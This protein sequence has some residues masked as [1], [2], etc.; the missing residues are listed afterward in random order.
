MAHKGRFYEIFDVFSDTILSGNPVAIVHETEGLTNQQ[1]QAIAREFNLSETVFMIPPRDPKHIARLRIFKPDGEMAFAGHPTI[2]AAVALA[3]KNNFRNDALIILEEEVGIIRAVVD[4][5]EKVAFAEFDLP[6]LPEQ[7]PLDTPREVFAAAFGLE[8]KEIGFEN[9]VPSLWTAGVPFFFVP[10]HNLKTVASALPDPVYIAE[11]FDKLNVKTPSFYLYSRETQLFQSS[12]HVR[13]FR[14][15]GWEDAATGSAA[16]AFCGVV[17][18]FDHPLDGKKNIWLEQGM[19]MNRVSK[20]RLEWYV[21][22]RK[23]V[24]AR[25][26]GNAVKYAEGRI[27]L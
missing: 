14:P 21:E 9:H 27:F 25:I 23:L 11:N 7:L 1:M 6:K 19:E 18:H 24:S 22:N 12:F 2:G 26:G 4:Q 5:K 3:L 20:L 17:Q 13:M 15:D 16:S 10:L 8:S